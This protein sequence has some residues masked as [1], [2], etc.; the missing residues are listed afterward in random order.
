MDASE[1]EKSM[2]ATKES[3]KSFQKFVEN[4]KWFFDNHESLQEKY[5]GMFVAVYDRAVC[6][7]DKDRARLGSRVRA[8]YGI[9]SGAVIQ[10]AGKKDMPLVV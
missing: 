1:K 8:K 2:M 7:S 6:M 5:K 3:K 4:G 9:N 10:F